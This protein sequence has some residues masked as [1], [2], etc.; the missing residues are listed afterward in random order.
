MS[1]WLALYYPINGDDVCSL[2][3]LCIFAPDQ[4]ATITESSSMCRAA[5][6]K[7]RNV[8]YSTPVNNRFYVHERGQCFIA[9][10]LCISGS[11]YLTLCAMFYLFG[12][13]NLDFFAESTSGWN[14]SL[15]V[16]DCNWRRDWMHEKVA[17]SRGVLHWLQCHLV[18]LL[19]LFA[20]ITVIWSTLRDIAHLSMLQGSSSDRALR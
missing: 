20:S 12:W 8:V 18:L 10:V 15:K 7:K 6:K 9:N 19:C 4:G 14:G 13:T 17:H 5:L 3:L 2:V 16:A 1:L 11:V